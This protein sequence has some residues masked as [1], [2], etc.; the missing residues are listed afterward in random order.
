MKRNLIDE[1]ANLVFP[2]NIHCLLC[3]RQILPSEKY[4]LCSKCREKMMFLFEKNCC[5][6]CG[7]PL[8]YKGE[9]RFCVECA[10]Q[11]LR[12]EK[13][14]S[15]LYYDDFSRKLIFQL[16]YGKKEYFAYHMAEMMMDRLEN[17]GTGKFDYIVP[18][19]LHAERE[20]ERGFNQALLLAEPLGKMRG[21]PVLKKFLE[22]KRQTVDQT[23]LGKKERFE[24]LKG[25]FATRGAEI[26]KGRRVL[27]IDDVFTTGATSN[28]CSRALMDSGAG[29]VFVATVACR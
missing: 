26:I 5:N 17:S 11:K 4:S 3:G 25:S 29:E 20:R 28:D 23:N 9:E 15:C 21:E 13:A 8:S 22:R 2:R 6:R 19:P 18:V 12:F 14:V 24:N 16:K 27:L 10:G 1:M 7:R